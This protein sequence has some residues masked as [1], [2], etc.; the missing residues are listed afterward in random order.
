MTSQKPP[1]MPFSLSKRKCIGCFQIKP[2][3]ELIKITKDFKTKE[4]V[5]N[6]NT[7]TFGRSVYICANKDCV[8]QA[9]KKNKISKFLRIKTDLSMEEILK[10]CKE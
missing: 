3:N 8:E 5:V 10:Y 9:F 4:V 2:K 1:Q 7:R 6:P